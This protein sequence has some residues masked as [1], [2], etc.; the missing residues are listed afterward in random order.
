MT[1]TDALRALLQ[2]Y[3]RAADDRDLDALKAVFHPDAEITGAKG[4]MTVGEW[5]TTMAAPRAFPTS[6][7]MMG[8]PLIELDEAGTGAT[9]DTYAV[10][11]QLAA[12]GG[13]DLTLGI[14]YVDEAVLMSE[15]WVIRRRR[16]ETRWM[17]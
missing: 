11:Y 2:R 5:L 16:S 13:D 10:V 7:H 17:R 4:T 1:T 12:E 8:E 9:L 6:M 15:R 3:A 14:R